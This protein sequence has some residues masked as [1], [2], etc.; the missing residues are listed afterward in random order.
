[1]EDVLTLANS[2]PIWIFAILIVCVVIFQAVKFINLSIKISPEAGLTK[3][4]VKKSIKV[5][6]INSLGPSLGIMIVVLSLVTLIGDPL[7]LIRIGIVGSAPMELLGATIGSQAAGT[8]LGSS[9]FTARAFTAVIWVLCL[10]GIGW[11]VVTALFTK[12]FGKMEKKLAQKDKSGK[13]VPTITSAALLGGFGF[14]LTDQM[15]NS[16]IHTIVGVCSGIAMIFVM[17]IANSRNIGWLKE[18]ALGIALVFGLTIA[19]FI[20]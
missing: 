18:W 14:F 1:M 12:S 4:E 19:F 16:S 20:T 8:E 13:I 3:D 5:G 10:G 11:L 2:L 17:K 6:A 7:T 15:S 9:D